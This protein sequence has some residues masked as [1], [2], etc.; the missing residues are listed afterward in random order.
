MEEEA[1]DGDEHGGV[2][3]L[4]CTLFESIVVVLV[5]GVSVEAL[6]VVIAYFCCCCFIS[7]RISFRLFTLI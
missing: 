3:Y 1:D 5:V 2:S 6:V 7:S 4:R